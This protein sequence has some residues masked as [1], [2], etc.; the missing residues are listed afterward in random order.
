MAKIKRTYNLSPR[1]VSLVRHLAEESHVA[2]TQDA[3]VEAAIQSL[4]RRVRD[5]EH[6]RQ[7]AA[8]ARD[9]EFQREMAA[10][11]AEFE[12]DDRAAWGAG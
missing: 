7:F 8:C 10:I 3:V 5:E 9:P 11:G 4:G 6:A 1:T 12:A 2:P